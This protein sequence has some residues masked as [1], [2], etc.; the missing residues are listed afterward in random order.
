MSHPG[1]GQPPDA[2]R[3]KDIAKEGAPQS[4][5]PS[6]ADDAVEGIGP[7]AEDRTI[8]AAVSDGRMGPGGD[9]VEGKR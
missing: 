8:P 6:R 9:P 1:A 3:P 2:T 4:Y 7:A 5:P